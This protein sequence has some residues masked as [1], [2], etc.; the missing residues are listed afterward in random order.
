MAD[1]LRTDV[2]IRPLTT[3][4]W[5]A[6]ADLFSSPGAPSHCWCMAW[7][8]TTDDERRGFRAAALAPKPPRGA[9]SPG[10]ALR[11]DA[12]RRRVDAGVP[13]GLI[14]Y[15]D[16]EPVAWCSVGPRPTFRRLGGPK[17]Q[18]DD[19][20]VVWS[21]DCFFVKRAWRGRGLVPRLID[22][23]VAY[24][25]EGGARLVEAYPVEPDAPRFRFMGV[26]PAFEADGFVAVAPAGHGRT[27]MRRE[28]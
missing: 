13:V 3:G 17:D 12:M 15:A 1:D 16:A 4:H 6:F 19:P 27:V 9:P 22:A 18:A 25:R 24:A 7:R 20:A 5:P 14:A 2:I 26:V 28:V 10:S 23:A 8:A 11:R 21:I